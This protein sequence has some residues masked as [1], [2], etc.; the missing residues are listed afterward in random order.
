M[1]TLI[2]PIIGAVSALLGGFAGAWFSYVQMR[3]QLLETQRRQLSQALGTFARNCNESHT[4]LLERVFESEA[5]NVEMLGAGLESE[6]RN[7]KLQ[8]EV[9]RITGFINRYLGDLRGEALGLRLEADDDSLLASIRRFQEAIEEAFAELVELGNRQEIEGERFTREFNQLTQEYLTLASG[10]SPAPQSLLDALN[11]RKNELNDE[12]DRSFHTWRSNLV[13]R[14][15]SFRVDQE[16]ENVVETGKA[17]VHNNESAGKRH[18]NL[19]IK[20]RTARK[21]SE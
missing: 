1:G 17:A 3:L 15:V 20:D 8:A 12:L 4:L 21:R 10:E 9:N 11:L 6:M 2:G 5:T 18:M 14:A 19:S 7:R 13:Q 16:I